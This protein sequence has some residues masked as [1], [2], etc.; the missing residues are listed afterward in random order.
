MTIRKDWIIYQSSGLP[1]GYSFMH[2]AHSDSFQPYA[3]KIIMSDKSFFEL[4]PTVRPII[5]GHSLIIQPTQKVNH[6]LL[7]NHLMLNI[8]II[9]KTKTRGFIVNSINYQISTSRDLF[10][11]SSLTTIKKC[12]Y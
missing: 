5:S 1:F 12:M 8:V 4:P 10:A 2:H 3:Y 11:G 6:L 7:C 9:L